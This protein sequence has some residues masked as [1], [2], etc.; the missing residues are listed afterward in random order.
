MRCLAL[1]NERGDLGG[2]VGQEPQPHHVRAPSMPSSLVRSQPHEC[3]RCEMRPSDPV[4]HLM[5]LR[6]ATRRLDRLALG[7]G[8]S[9]AWDGDMTHAELV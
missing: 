2:I 7:A 3:L 1:V 6:E 8:A 5:S 4:R 9:L